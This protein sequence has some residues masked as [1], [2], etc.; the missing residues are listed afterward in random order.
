MQAQ[1]PDS[2]EVVELKVLTPEHGVCSRLAGGA[3]VQHVIQTQLAVVALFRWKVP[4]LDNPQLEN[5]VHPTTVILQ[6]Y[7]NE[8]CDCSQSLD[9][10]EIRFHH[11][12]YYLFHIE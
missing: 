5:I 6:W 11:C 2:R 1:A 3:C 12:Q 8:M 9:K 4:R 10:N 7:Q